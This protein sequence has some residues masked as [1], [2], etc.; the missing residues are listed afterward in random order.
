M[1][2]KEFKLMDWLVMM[3]KKPWCTDGGDG[4]KGSG[5]MEVTEY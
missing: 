3:L 2:E 1:G 4:V 5:Y